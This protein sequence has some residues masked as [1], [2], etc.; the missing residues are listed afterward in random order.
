MKVSI[1]FD[2]PLLTTKEL[3][4]LKKLE[5]RAELCILFLESSVYKKI[6]SLVKIQ[7]ICA[8]E[9][10]LQKTFKIS[11]DFNLNKDKVFL[12]GF[13]SKSTKFEIC[14][15]SLV[16]NLSSIEILDTD[17]E[18]IGIHNHMGEQ[19]SIFK[20][21]EKAFKSRKDHVIIDIQI[22]GNSKRLLR[23][24]LEKFFLNDFLNMQSRIL[25]H[26]QDLCDD[27]L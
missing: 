11:R 25:F 19:E 21:V 1:V 13:D 2:S 5:K 15:A 6:V 14:H 3:A 26:I 8:I 24:E 16:I 4:F 18:I 23:Y 17:V 10:F 20:I 27:L 7:F 22:N 12:Y 9:I